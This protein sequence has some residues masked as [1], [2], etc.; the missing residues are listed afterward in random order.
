MLWMKYPLS[1]SLICWIQAF[2]WQAVELNY[3][4]WF[5]GYVKT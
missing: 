5:P 2:A 3:W 4:D 1:W